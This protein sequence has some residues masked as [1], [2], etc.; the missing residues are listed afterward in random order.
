MRV[1]KIL[2]ACEESQVVCKEFRKLGHESYS[3]DIQECSGGHPEWH[4]Q[5]DA[6]KAIELRDW[7]LMIANPPCTYISRAGARWMYKGGDIDLRRYNKMHNAVEFFMALYNSNI[8]YVAVENSTPLKIA[9]LPQ[10]TQAIQPYQFGHPYSKRT[11]LWLKNLSELKYT[12]AIKDYIPYMPSN[13]GGKKRGQKATPRNITQKE[14]SVT[15]T[16]IAK[17]MAEQWSEYILSNEALHT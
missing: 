3:C 14:A 6:I 8:K 15:F 1:L 11:L 13:T 12:S 10:Y 2:V 17:A 5:M 16:G 4:L 9:R 7:D